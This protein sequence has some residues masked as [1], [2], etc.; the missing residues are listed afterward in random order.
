MEINRQLARA[1][2]RV[3]VTKKYVKWILLIQPLK[4][5]SHYAFFALLF[6][7]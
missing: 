6:A 7:I 2:K 3:N 4:V 1:D 5:R